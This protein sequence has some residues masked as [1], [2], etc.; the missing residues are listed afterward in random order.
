MVASYRADVGAQSAFDRLAGELA[1]YYRLGVERTPGDLDGKGRP[2]KV[3]VSRGN[4]AVR[5]RAIFDIRTYEDRDR[6]A[7]LNAALNASAPA[8]GIGLRITSYVAADRGDPSRVKLV[9]AGEASRL[10]DG[11]AT[12]Q[13]VVR[14][15]EGR[16]VA[17]S[18]QPLG[19]AAGGQLPFS[20]N[21]PVAPGRYTVRFAVMDRAGHVGSVDHRADAYKV[22][23][24]PLYGFGPLLVRVPATPGAQPSVVLGGV[25]QNN[26]LALQLDLA[27]EAG[28]LD[29]ADVVFE[30]AS[31]AD[32]PALVQ[33]SAALS[34]SG[35]RGP[36]LA[37]AIADV[38]LLPPGAYVAR[39]MVSSGGEALG[40]MRRTFE[41]SG[42]TVL[43]AGTAPPG[44]DAA[45]RTVPVR[46]ASQAA[47]IVPPFAVDQVLEPRVLG[48]FLE[49]GGRAIGCVIA[50]HPASPPAGAYDG[51]A[52]PARPRDG[53]AGGACGNGLPRE[54]CR[55]SPTRSWIQRQTSSATHCA[56]HPTST[57]PWCTSA[58][59]MRPA[60]RTAKLPRRGAP[61]SF[62]W[63]TS[64][65]CT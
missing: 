65:P 44:G 27:G 63:T 7:R 11:D 32:G 55:C 39:A 8:T 54:G 62:G 64:W 57:P 22:P 42:P 56:P 19:T 9:L 52:R 59:A 29:G 43:V 24:G 3:Q 26:R 61:R 60:G 31:T 50:G 28:L 47:V 1:G 38:R 34:T 13:V 33:S 14:D 10:A 36:A 15:E 23:L 49:S 5:A 16:Q 58:R 41:I 37:E 6:T 2:L 45:A 20:V 25:R 30:I 17:S 51:R 35:E 4:V 46:L 18:E 12:F 40:T 53:Q 21:L 48:A